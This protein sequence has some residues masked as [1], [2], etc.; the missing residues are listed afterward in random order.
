MVR[1]HASHL[2]ADTEVEEEG[3]E[4]AAAGGRSQS[5]APRPIVGLAWLSR[6]DAWVAAGQRDAACRSALALLRSGPSG[7]QLSPELRNALLDRLSCQLALVDSALRDEIAATLSKAT[8]SA[9]VAK[10]VL[11]SLSDV[12]DPQVRVRLVR[13]A[14]EA[15]A[16]SADHAT[17]LTDPDA[18]IRAAAAAALRQAAETGDHAAEEALR[19]RQSTEPDPRVRAALSDQKTED[20][21]FGEDRRRAVPL[22]PAAARAREQTLQMAWD[23]D[24]EHPELATRCQ[25]QIRIDAD[26]RA[27]VDTTRVEGDERWH[28]TYPAWAWKDEAG[29]LIIDARGQS[30][31]HVVSPSGDNWSPDSL[32]IAP[33]GTATTIDD[34]WQREQGGSVFPGAG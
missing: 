3:L 14:L 10:R 25:S 20:L 23:L 16:P 31:N 34:R 8:L 11:N 21:A 28:V 33:D 1:H 24:P 18:R 29:N 27:F 32:Q 5:T 26:G 15:A 19:T 9:D 7:P 6:F 17:L 2:A 12:H 30:V 4:V 22:P 13:K